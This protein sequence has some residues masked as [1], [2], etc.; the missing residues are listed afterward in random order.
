MSIATTPEFKQLVMAMDHDIPADVASDLLAAFYDA[1]RAEAAADVRRA[2]LP[3]FPAGERVELVAQMMRA[4]DARIAEHGAE[5]PYGVAGQSLTPVREAEIRARVEAATEGPWHVENHKPS[6]ERLVE[7][8]TGLLSVSLGYLGNNNQDD[9]AFI[10]HAREDVPALLAELDRLR[11]E[12]DALKDRLHRAALA[13]T[14][15]NEDG[16]KFVFVEDIAGPLLG[17]DDAEAGDR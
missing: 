15:R 17:R 7:D 8:E 9:A 13:R 6:L 5:A 14:W 12:R 1:V 16:K 3:S 11:V 2:E 4:I 10:A